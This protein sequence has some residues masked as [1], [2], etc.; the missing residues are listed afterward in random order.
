MEMDLKNYLSKENLKNKN[1]K[2][3]FFYRIC[4]TGMGA[5]ALLLRDK[6]FEVSGY[7]QSFYPPMGDY[8]KK[9]GIDLSYQKDFNLKGYDLII[10]G[11]VVG[12]NSEDAR[13][14]E[15]S[16]TPFTSFPAALGALVLRGLNVVGVAGT[17][18]KTTTTHLLVQ[19]FK[20][21]GFDPGYLIGGVL[22]GGPS[23]HLGDG[24]FFFIE[25]DEYDSS[26]FEKFSKFRSYEIDH[27]IITSLEFDHADIFG[28]LEEIKDQFRTLIPNIKNAIVANMNYPAIKELR[29]EFG[30]EWIELTLPKDLKMGVGGS[31]FTL[32]GE[33]YHTGLVG[34][35]NIL[36]LVSALLFAL[37]EGIKPGDLKKA[38]KNLDLVKRRQE[39]RGY[40]KGAMVIDD[41]AHHPRA[42]KM[43]FEAISTKY[44]KKE[45]IVVLD[46]ASA[47][48]RSNIFQ[49]EFAE[50]ISKIP[51]VVLAKPQHETTVF[52]GVNLDCEMLVKGHENATVVEDLKTLRETLD[53]LS[54]DKSLLLILSNSTCLGLWESDFINHLK[55]GR[56]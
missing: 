11:N 45:I 38:I 37:K 16:K 7:D 46:P 29:D 13:E 18:G 53:L 12:K 2:K 50:V 54:S 51:Q 48:A 47:T 55:S 56:K 30:G 34:D 39:F 22:P 10:V 32:Q 19:I 24:S 20:K 25:S 15:N 40:Y 27:L 14:I 52:G 6:G 33:T 49:N 44:P 3:I 9:S 31:E 26:Y 42:V 23:S 43:T 28:S 5:A 36:N 35:H 21:L 17:H 1:F 41:F 8:L 4:G